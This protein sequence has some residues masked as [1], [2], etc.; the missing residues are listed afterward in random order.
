MHVLSAFGWYA[1]YFLIASIVTFALLVWLFVDEDNPNDPMCPQCG[2]R[3]SEH[4]VMQGRY[5]E[6]YLECPVGYER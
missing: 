1:L 2:Y 5:D 6:E 3:V 4:I